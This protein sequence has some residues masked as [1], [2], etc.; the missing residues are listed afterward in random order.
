MYFKY[1]SQER[2][3]RISHKQTYLDSFIFI[4]T[5]KE[6]HWIHF[7]VGTI[8]DNVNKFTNSTC[9]AVCTMIEMKEMENVVMVLS[10]V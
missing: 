4:G 8:F 9:T 3:P 6:G 10:L 2:Q 1:S 7:R 5:R